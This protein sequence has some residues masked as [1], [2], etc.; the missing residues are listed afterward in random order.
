MAEQNFGGSEPGDRRRGESQQQTENPERRRFLSDT[1]SVASSF[2]LAGAFS[3]LSGCLNAGEMPAAKAGPLVE[4]ADETTGLNLLKLPEGF[5]YRTFGWTRDKM[6]DG[7]VT[8]GAH[9][10]M[11]VVQS[12]GDIV[13]LVRNHE[14]G[15]VTKSIPNPH[16]PY[17]PKAGGGC[18]SLRFNVAKGEWIDSWVSM[19]GT[20]R[21]CAGGPTPWGTWLTCE[22]TIFGPGDVYND[23]TYNFEKNHGW[24][25]DVPPSGQK[26]PEP[27]KGM[28]RFVHEAIAIDRETGIVYETED[29]G[30]AGFYRYLPTDKANLAA[31]GD[32]QMMKVI[33]QPDLT[34]HVANGTIFD[35]EWVDIGDPEL[36][37][38]PYTK[39]AAGVF[40]QGVA[41]EGTAFARLEGCWYGS[42]KVYFDAT[43]GGG[44]KVGQ[45]WAFDPEQQKLQMLFESPGAETLNMPDNLCVSPRGGLLL[46]EDSDYGKFSQQRI[47]GLS[48]DGKLSL[49][50]INNI[51]LA[52]EK[53]GFK[54]DFRG[55]EWAGSTFSPDGKW[56]F[57]NIQTPGI[58]FA[59]TG[60]WESTVF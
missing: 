16:P 4:V 55:R 57:V 17:D 40:K 19:S 14:I 52:G 32:L 58:T 7:T 48:Q 36:A 50:A 5:R 30:R 43:S 59:I 31:G 21:N 29:R 44:S 1:F 24:I 53:N 10:G 11:A 9:D 33:G 8:P 49:F 38:S 46:C 39:D 3:S 2:A 12:D 47:H 51:Q 28:G 15:S 23:V 41:L 13:T 35:V 18:T 25:F 6:K 60:P 34:G 45:I 22:E 20:V 27:I 56:L 42:G 26:R 37:H 54:G